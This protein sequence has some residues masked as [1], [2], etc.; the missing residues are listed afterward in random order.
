MTR[1]YSS[2]ISIDA[3]IVDAFCLMQKG[4]TDQFVYYRKDEPRRFMGLGRCV[5][6]PTLE[7][8]ECEVEGPEAIQPV[9]FSFNRFDAENPAPTDELF[10]AFPRLRFMLPEVVLVENVQGTFLQVNSLSP[11]YRGRV[12]RFL[13]QAAGAPCRKRRAIPYT[14]QPDSREEWRRAVGEALEAIDGGAVDKVVLSRR[15][16]LVAEQPFSSKD[17]LVNLIDGPARGTV[18]LYRYADVFFCGCTPELLVRKDGTQVESMCLA[19]T[20]PAGSTEEERRAL[21]DGLMCDA[22]NRAEHDYVV[23]HVRDVFNR[24]CYGVDVLATP[25]IMSLTHVQHLHTPA[26]AHILDGMGLWE[27]MGDL[28]PTP[29]VSGTPVGEARML[30]RRIEAYNRGFFAGACGYIDGAGDGEFSVGLRTGVFD[31]E[32]GW[33]YA[34][35]GIVA[36][37]V[38]DD[39]YDE[40][41]LK[42]KTILDAFEA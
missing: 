1:I 40:I 19:G 32:I 17:L 42:L 16:K 39:E 31:G 5:A 27:L 30:I 33:L 22:K 36:G 15:Q 34:G 41:G 2:S 13:R 14:V 28:H 35:C 7:G 18:L 6:F 9:F 29:A 24:V 37:S 21:A 11:V 8:V 10:E 12:E 20:C 23:R 38:A 4:F 3:D 26:R 25:R